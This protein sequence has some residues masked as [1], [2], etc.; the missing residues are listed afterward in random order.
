TDAA[1][2]A[3]DYLEENYSDQSLSLSRMAQDLG[4]NEKYLSH[5]LSKSLGKT[6]SEYLKLLRIKHAVFLMENGVSTIKN[7]A[8]L[9]GF[10]DPLYFSR[11]FTSVTGKTP[12][13]FVKEL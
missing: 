5:C 7:I 9:V 12:R 1:T 11:V 4:Y 6:F 2:A 13:Q 8:Y 10:G 3:I